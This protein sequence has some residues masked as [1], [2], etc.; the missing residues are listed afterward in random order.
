VSKNPN[1]S[2]YTHGEQVTLTANPATGWSFSAW[3]GGTTGS[4]NPKTITITGNTTITATF[5]QIQYTL[6]I[7][8]VGSGT[9]SKNPNKSTYTYGEQVTLTATPATGWSFS[10]WSGGTSSPENPLE[11]IITENITLTAN[12]RDE[13][14]P[15]I[16]WV[17]PVKED[18]FVHY[19]LDNDPILL[20]VDVTEVTGVDYVKF[21]R[22]QPNPGMWVDIAVVRNEPFK[23]QF[24]SRELACGWNEIDVDAYDLNGNSSARSFIWI[25]KNCR[26][27]MPMI[28]N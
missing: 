17:S 20:E 9:V 5:T 13:R 21:Y 24:S 18:P 25:Y 15:L 16:E 23:A 7:N 14:S 12:F 1:Q 26:V 8:M 22:Y 19:V 11:I 2:T 3:S 4:D 10:A 27:F 6:T 28:N